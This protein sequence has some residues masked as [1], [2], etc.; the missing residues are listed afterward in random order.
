MTSFINKSGDIGL[1]DT[2][3]LLEYGVEHTFN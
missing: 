3:N 1:F 2:L